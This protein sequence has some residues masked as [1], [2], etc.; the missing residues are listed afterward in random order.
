MVKPRFGKRIM[1]I[2]DVQAKPGD[3]FEFLTHIGKYAVKM[4]PAVIVCIGDFADMP[5]LSTYEP[6]GSKKFEGRR[7]KKDIEAAKQAMATLMAPIIKEQRRLARLGKVWKP[8]LVLT[9]GN[10]EHRIPRAVDA[11]PKLDGLISLKDLEY[12]KWGWKCYEFLKPVCI[13]NVVFSH[14]MVSGV[15]GR[16]VTTARALLTKHHQSCIVGH[17][18][19]RDIAYSKRADGTD[20]TAIICGSCYEHDEDYLNPQTNNHWRGLYMLLDVTPDGSFDEL[21]ISLNWLRRK[22]GKQT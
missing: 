2:P 4:K 18:Q 22:Y 10:H 15:M 21:P 11:D 13:D 8:K 9:Y 14:Y 20:M 5:S 12:E 1:V 17:Q 19:G 16:P 3:D 7:Y 6:K